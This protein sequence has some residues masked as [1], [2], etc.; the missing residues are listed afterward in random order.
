[1][2]P[3]PVESAL[4]VRVPEAEVLVASWRRSLDPSAAWGVPAHITL[5][6][7]FVAPASL[8]TEVLSRVEAA[9]SSFDPFRFTLAAARTF[10][11]DV[12]YLEPHP[13]DPFRRLTELLAD[14][15][16]S[17]PPYGGAFE[18]IVPHLTVAYQA[19]PAEMR[20]ARSAVEQ[21][22][23]VVCMATEV[24]LLT[25]SPAPGAWR[26]AAT[27]GLGRRARGTS[28]RG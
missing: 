3:D 12:L 4:V 1:M 27:F 7:P 9:L 21:G 14:A 15:F 20:L 6:Y 22:L 25:G 5:L 10:G 26:V 19:P 28:A 8:D 2:H 16:P 11:D 13:A 23:P 18:E 24:A 17:E